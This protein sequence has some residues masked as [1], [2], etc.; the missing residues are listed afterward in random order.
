MVD[1]AVREQALTSLSSSF[2]ILTLDAPI[3]TEFSQTL[4]SI[5]PFFCLSFCPFHSLCLTHSHC[6]HTV[7]FHP[8]CSF[9]S[10]I[11]L[12]LIC[13]REQ[14]LPLLEGPSS[15]PHTGRRS[16]PHA[17]NL[18]NNQGNMSFEQQMYRCQPVL[19]GASCS[20]SRGIL[21]GSRSSS[22]HPWHSTYMTFN[23]L[24]YTCLLMCLH[25]ALKCILCEE[26]DFAYLIHHFILREKNLSDS[27]ASTTLHRVSSWV[28]FCSLHTAQSY[29]AALPG[30][31]YFLMKYLSK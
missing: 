13:L 25:P 26:R 11:W 10:G 21:C 30:I 23:T 9:C 5:R 8:L 31:T 24:S 29:A 16:S 12:W 3:K 15:L 14:E 19:H 22:T 27:R 18:Y 6:S 4:E 1:W 7:W 2:C 20:R 17:E 28:L